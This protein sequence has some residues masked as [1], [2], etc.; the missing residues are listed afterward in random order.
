VVDRAVFINYRGEDSHSCCALL[1]RDLTGQFGEDLVFLDAESIPAGADFVEE[2]LARVRSARVLLAVIGP[3]WLTATDPTTGRRRIDDPADWIR[4]ELA[5]AFTASIRVIPVLTDQAGLP[6]DTDLPTDIAAL[7]RCQYRHLR[8]RESKS[9]LAR[10]VADLTNLDPVLAA[11]ARNRDNAPRQ[12][13][14]APGPFTGRATELATLTDAATTSLDAGATVVILAIGGVGG[15]GKTALAL[16]WAYQHLHRFPDGQLYV[17]LRGFDPSGQPT[18]V[19]DAVRG[20]LLGLGVDLSTLPDDLDA[21]AARYRS[22]VAGKGML[23]VLDNARDLD[24]VTPLLPGSPTCTVLVTSRRHLAGITRYG[25]RLLDL[26]VLP[27]AEARDLLARHL[28]SERLVAEP[29]AVAELLAVCAGLPLAVAIVAALAQRHPT[30]RLAVLAEELRDV[31]ARLDGL[32]AGDLHVNLRAALSSSVRALSPP[33]ASVFG[34]LGI[35]PGPHISLPAAASLAALPEGQARAVLRELENASLV[36]QHAPGRYRMHDLVRLY[37]TETACHDL[38]EDARE[39]ALR[40]VLDFYTHTAHTA[41]RLLSPHR[42]PVQLDLPAPGAYPQPLPDVPAALGWL[43]TEHPVLLAAQR[44]AASHV[45]YTLVWRLAW[46]LDTFHGRRGHRHDRLAVWRG[47]LDAA[48]YLPGPTPRILAHRLFGLSYAELGRHEEGIGHLHQALALAE[49]YH[50]ID[51]QARAHRVLAM[52]WELRGDNRQAM[53]HATRSL[54]LHR[55]TDVPGWEADAFN[56]VGW[57]AARSAEYDTARRHCQAALTL[58]RQ[59]HNPEGEAAT[60]D[61]LGYIAHHTGHHR[62]AIRYYQ[63]AF[64]LYRAVGNTS[65]SADTLDSLGHPHIAAGEHE[66]ARTAWR[67]ALDL[68]Q[69]QG[70][71]TDAARVQQQL[72]DL[73]HRDAAAQSS[74]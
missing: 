29:A 13:P 4:R 64:T 74:E 31:S 16:H 45:W 18:A 22:L 41:D 27:E 35:A 69:N 44:T 23:I 11:A 2:L 10:I 7:S 70:R 33:A 9:D 36:Q 46:A 39:A 3:S 68:Y 51:Q 52:A 57:Y 59:H 58:Y 63:Q 24:Q 21:L 37:A 14:T 50:D 28:R 71:N 5:E 54:D 12:L 25:A 8:R 48:A 38:A 65:Q 19:R 20:F 40:R 61:S 30:F 53:R 1:Y 26:D 6:R 67:E 66:H 62:Q 60:L 72:D 15:I 73:D 49:E 43:D 56:I 47:A 32:D 42:P 55:T 34:L 17:D